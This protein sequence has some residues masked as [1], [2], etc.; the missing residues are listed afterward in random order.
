MITAQL[1]LNCGSIKSHFGLS[2][3]S[4]GS[5]QLCGS[6]YGQF[7]LSLHTVG[8]VF[9]LTLVQFL[10]PFGSFYAQFLPTLASR[11]LTLSDAVQVDRLH[12]YLSDQGV[13]PGVLICNGDQV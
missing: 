10:L 3:F 9:G 13:I 1:W 5:V 12:N 2:V 6:V 8:S 7:G 11:S 4:L